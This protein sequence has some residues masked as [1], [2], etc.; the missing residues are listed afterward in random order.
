MPP[1][2]NRGQ[3]ELLIERVETKVNVV[4]LALRKLM[5]VAGHNNCNFIIIIMMS[6]MSES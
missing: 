1:F 2:C 6:Q 4:G 3:H 5:A